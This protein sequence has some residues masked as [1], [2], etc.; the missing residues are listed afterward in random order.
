[1]GRWLDPPV[2]GLTIYRYRRRAGPGNAGLAAAIRKRNAQISLA[3][4]RDGGISLSSLSVPPT[5]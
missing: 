3:R 5:E 2:S 1:M 4:E